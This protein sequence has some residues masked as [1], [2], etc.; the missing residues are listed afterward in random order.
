VKKT[1]NLPI[2]SSTG[3]K[4]RK[5]RRGF[6]PVKRSLLQVGAMYSDERIQGKDADNS[7]LVDKPCVFIHNIN[8]AQLLIDEACYFGI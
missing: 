6:V 1:N 3:S 5:A 8:R 2:L 7:N 4:G